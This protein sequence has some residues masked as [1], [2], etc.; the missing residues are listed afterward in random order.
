MVDNDFAVMGVP[1]ST[2][3]QARRV[4]RGVFIAWRRLSRRTLFLSSELDLELFFTPDNPLY[5]KA[6]WRTWRYLVTRKPSVVFV[7][8]PQGLLLAEV[9]AI[10]RRVGLK[11][12]ADVHTGFIYPISPKEYILNRP[13]HVHLRRV[14]LVLAHN[15]LQADLIKKKTRI[16][17]EKVVLVYDPIPRISKSTG[18]SRLN[19]IDL[20]K[21]VVFPASW[22]IDEPL[23]YITTEFLESEIARDHI[24][25][26]TGS[27]RRNKKLYRKLMKVIK[28]RKAGDKVVLTGYLPDEEYYHLIKHC[29]AIIAMS[30][31]E[32]TL[33][34][35]LWEAVATE[36]PFITLGTETM[37]IEISSEYPC[38]FTMNKGSLRRTLDYCLD[39]EYQKAYSVAKAKVEELRFKSKSTLENLV[40]KLSEIL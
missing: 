5:L 4:L 32:Y 30:S 27:W 11:V 2:C 35:A 8:L 25:V 34:H 23:N 36:K 39:K 14:D 6:M 18:L 33:P 22:A 9:T 26:I 24:L 7:Q 1:V 16:S 19:D 31:R 20:G 40:K 21:S 38:F 3:P 17:S 29:K 37:L 12:V 13:F 15:I 10:S 28:E